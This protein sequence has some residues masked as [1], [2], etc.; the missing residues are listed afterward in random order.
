RRRETMLRCHARLRVITRQRLSASGLLQVNEPSLD[1]LTI[2]KRAILLLEEQKASRSIHASIEPRRVKA[3]ERNE[4]VGLRARACGVFPQHECQ[5]KRFVTKLA[6]D[7]AI[8]LR[9]AVALVEEQV[10]HVKDAVHTL[11]VDA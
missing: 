5:T 6:A 1:E 8:R 4:R 11:R 7:H 3:H 10:E 9:G 2:P